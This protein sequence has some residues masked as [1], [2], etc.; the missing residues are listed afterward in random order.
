[1][2]LPPPQ[3]FPAPP[4]GPPVDPPSVPFA[5]ITALFLVWGFVSSVIDGL[6]PAVR[7]IFHLSFAAQMLT[8]FAF[9]AAYGAVSLPAAV[10][11]A[12]VGAPRAIELA[13]GV[14]VAG[15]LVVLLGTRTQNY[16]VI[17]LALFVI[18][19]GITLL[20]VAANPLVAAHGEP[21]RAH[22]RLTLAQA[23]NSLGT[24]LGPVVAGHLLLRGGLFGSGSGTG[25]GTAPDGAIAPADGARLVSL[26]NI[27][28]Q[29]ELIALLVAILA[30]AVW[31]VRRRL[32]AADPMHAVIG[33]SL[34]SAFR[35]GWG[36]FGAFAVFVYVGSEVGVSTIMVNFLS[37]P[38][39]LGVSAARAATLL[40]VVFWGGAM[41]GRFAGSQLLRVVSAGRVLGV[42]AIINVLLCLTVSQTTGEPAG[43]AALLTGFFNSVMFPTLFT[44]TLERSHA[45][46]ASVSGL[47]CSAIA[48]GAVVPPLV[49]L[50]ADRSGISAGFA[51]PLAGYVGIAVFALF[52]PARPVRHRRGFLLSRR[53]ARAGG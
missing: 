32:D 41:L 35:S 47:L 4:A 6:A 10:L 26:H 39:I 29:F 19:S 52:A 34:V 37:Q 12:R 20:Q 46:A 51:V 31:R 45:P 24:V 15:C 14:T 25:S 13:L 11:L 1:M 8:Q 5:A 36:L 9:F 42:F 33:G 16:G 28:R 48:G 17:L 38:A 40:G 23:F 22:M 44:L 27:D 53:A 18:A 7:A 30:L 2:V 43:A 21:S 50:M 3:P 49:G